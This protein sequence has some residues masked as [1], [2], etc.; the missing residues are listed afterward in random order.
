MPELPE[1]ETIRRRLCGGDAKCPGLIGRR[2][3]GAWVGWARTLAEPAPPAF[4]R[5][6]RGQTIVRIERRAKH[7]LLGLSSDTLMIHLGM[8]GSLHLRRGRGGPGVTP[9][10]RTRIHRVP[11]D[12]ARYCRLSLRLSDGW[13]LDLDDPRKFG[14]VR[15][16]SDPARVL[17]DIG[18]EPLSREFTAA[19]LAARLRDH[20]RALKPLLLDQG[21]I[22][23]VGNIYADEALH[24]AGLHPR[25]RSD[26]LTPAQARALWRAIRAVL[27]EAIRW[28]G[29]TFDAVYGDGG[30]QRHLRVYQ[31]TGQ[32]CRECGTPIRRVVVAQRGTHFCP[33][34]QPG[35]Y[36]VRMT[37]ATRAAPDPASRRIR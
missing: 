29:T 7:L 3:Q 8:S 28:N 25:T 36:R 10:V 9:R 20:R 2:I 15:L 27:R 33:R 22:A 32:P 14:R 21:F 31:R 6:V 1:V 19:T 18:P 23:G 37:L 24:R 35:S 26:R 16:V 17:S 30:F 12:P 13:R 4:R 34:C 5:R 11:D